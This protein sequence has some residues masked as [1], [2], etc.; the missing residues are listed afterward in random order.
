MLFS[1]SFIS[2]LMLASVV[3]AAPSG[4]DNALEVRAPC[5]AGY[6]PN[7]KNGVCTVCPAGHYC[8]DGQSLSQCG[9]G[10]Y[11][12]KTGIAKGPCPNCPSG[13]YQPNQGQAN[14]IPAPKGA[15]VL[16]AG[17]SSYN[18]ASGGS[19][20]GVMG[21]NHT[22]MTCC[23]YSAVG[24]NNTV[25]T[26]C[27]KGTYAWPGSGSGCTNAKADCV[28]PATCTELANGTCPAGTRDH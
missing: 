18:V 23:G 24:N 15:Y 26:R 22:C 17:A 28:V 6:Y 10:Q 27:A 13:Q 19:F 21:Q 4:P 20:Q 8:P 14:C 5:Q 1:I 7:S 11:Q 2:T 3:Q 9:T 12:D 16:N 25:A